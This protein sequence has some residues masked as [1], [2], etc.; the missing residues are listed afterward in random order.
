MFDPE[1]ITAA[2]ERNRAVFSHL[3]SDRHPDATRWRP[4]PGKWNLLEIVCHLYD[5]EREDFRARVRYAL[6][7]PGTPLASIDPA[8]WVKSRDYA[9]QD[10]AEKLAAFLRERDASIAW[11][12]SLRSPRWDAAFE[13]PQLGRVTAGFFL[14]NWLAHDYLHLRQITRLEY[15]RLQQE[16]GEN[17]R[18]AGEW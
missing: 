13:H 11:L 4:A 9:A 14:A 16:A 10:F 12:R 15:Q 5:E 1:A 6:E 17:L 2:L 3:S 18:Y 7:S 8:G